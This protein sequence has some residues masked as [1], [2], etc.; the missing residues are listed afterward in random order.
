MEWITFLGGVGVGLFFGY[1]IVVLCARGAS[2]IA[3]IIE[4]VSK[5]V[6]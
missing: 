1:C 4:E 6:E 2:G 3:A 5:E